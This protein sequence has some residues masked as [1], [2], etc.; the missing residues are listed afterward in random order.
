MIFV[1]YKNKNS[2]LE[3]YLSKEIGTRVYTNRGI[4]ILSCLVDKILIDEKINKFVETYVKCPVCNSI[5][6]IRLKNSIN[7]EACGHSAS[8]FQ[9]KK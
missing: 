1:L 6:T 9:E 8:V 7:C 4:I 3:K 2:L 5:D